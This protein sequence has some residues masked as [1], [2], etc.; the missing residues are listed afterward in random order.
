MDDARLASRF[1][2]VIETDI[3]PLTQEGV[4]SGSK[5]FGAAILLK[6]D[7]SLIV[8]E[9]N[10]ETENP[11]WHGEVHAIKR[12]F[13]RDRA[14]LPHPRDCIFFATHEP[15]SLCLSAITWAGFDNFYYFFSYEDTRDAFAIPHDLRI[16]DEVFAVKEGRYRNPNG[17]WTAYAV[18]DMIAGL[19]D[20]L[21]AALSARAESIAFAYG[22]LSDDYQVT[23]GDAGIPLS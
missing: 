19:P 7:L 1:L 17:Y 23:K 12:F 2:D 15:C 16:L 8:A 9:T 22:K 11:L 18:R 13:E 20:E 3:V 21:R 14:T 5:V 4:E 6:S 10:N